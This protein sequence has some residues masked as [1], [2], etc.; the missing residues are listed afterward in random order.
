[1]ELK[2]NPLVALVWVLAAVVLVVV[3]SKILGTDLTLVIT[4]VGGTIALGV[5]V[6]IRNRRKT[7]STKDGL[8]AP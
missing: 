3:L 6:F 8:G 5:L 2:R 1:M 7:D 4:V